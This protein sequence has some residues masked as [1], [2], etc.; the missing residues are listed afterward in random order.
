VLRYL[1][2]QSHRD[3]FGREG[4]DANWAHILNMYFKI[5]HVAVW[6]AS[7]LLV[8]SD[9]CKYC[10]VDRDGTRAHQAPAAVARGIS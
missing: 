8:A 7:N 4:L 9:R 5:V 2:W 1:Y 3:P 10:R 6:L